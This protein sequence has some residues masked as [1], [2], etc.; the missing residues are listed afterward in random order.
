VAARKAKDKHRT[1]L[2]GTVMAALTNRRIELQHELDDEDVIAVLRKGVKTRQESVDQYRAGNRPELADREAAEI[3]ILQEFLPPDVDPEEIRSAVRQAIAGGASAVGAVMGQVMP[4][5][6][7]RADGRV[8]T[9][10]VRE[11]LQAG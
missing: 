10:I 11:E 8:I 9:Q 6:K 5:F 1:L 3:A 4:R 2:F 7:G